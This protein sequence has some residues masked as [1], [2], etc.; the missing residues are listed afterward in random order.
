H[1]GLRHGEMR[2]L[3]WSDID[4]KVGRLVVRRSVARGKVGTPKNGRAREV[5]LSQTAVAALVRHR[6]LNKLVFCNPDGSMLTR[7]QGKKQLSKAVRLSGIAKENVTWHDLRHTFAS[8]LVM[9][10]AQLKAVQ[11]LMGHA[12]I[13]MTMRYSHLCPSIKRDAV[14]LLD[15]ADSTSAAQDRGE[16]AKRAARLS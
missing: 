12:T 16:K 10:G 4:L 7:H 9:R 3:E 11:E 2:A 1:T 14:A 13:D 6:H 5:S 15:Q 8:H